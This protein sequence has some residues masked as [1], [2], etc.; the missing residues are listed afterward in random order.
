MM[1]DY[2][3]LRRTV[4]NRRNSLS[5][6]SY[7]SKQYRFF[8]PL[9]AKLFIILFIIW[10]NGGQLFLNRAD[11]CHIMALTCLKLKGG[12]ECGND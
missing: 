1:T 8:N 6:E 11:W 4:C 3:G 12:T 9:A 10:Q 2:V 5:S 7:H